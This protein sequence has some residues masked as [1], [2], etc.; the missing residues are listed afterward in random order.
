MWLDVSGNLHTK[1][2]GW[3]SH[4]FL[5]HLTFFLWAHATCSNVKNH[6]YDFWLLNWLLKVR[7]WGQTPSLL[8]NRVF[9]LLDHVSLS[10]LLEISPKVSWLP[11][12][13]G[14]CKDCSLSWGSQRG[15]LCLHSTHWGVTYT[16]KCSPGEPLAI[17]LP[18]SV[19]LSQRGHRSFPFLP[20][21]LSSP[22]ADTRSNFCL[23]SQEPAQKM[24]P[25]LMY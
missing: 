13:G 7:L 24:F 14:V 4:L 2:K 12:A 3:N 6:F 18:C 9:F 25:D 16:A 11:F 23:Y 20:Q 1:G 22:R 15:H 19:A 21:I 17:K 10:W 5:Y 8:T